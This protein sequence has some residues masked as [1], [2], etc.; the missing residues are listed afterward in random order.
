M[1]SQ[2]TQ[3]IQVD[4]EREKSSLVNTIADFIAYHKVIELKTRE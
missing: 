3:N 2:N 1:S 4:P